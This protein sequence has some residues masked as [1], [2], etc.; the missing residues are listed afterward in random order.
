MAAPG[1]HSHVSDVTSAVSRGNWLHTSHSLLSPAIN[2]C[3]TESLNDLYA[4]F[5]SQIYSHI[6]NFVMTKALFPSATVRFSLR[7]TFVA[8]T[9]AK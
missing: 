6:L 3:L 8:L 7:G 4:V 1:A 2:A 5:V 9:F